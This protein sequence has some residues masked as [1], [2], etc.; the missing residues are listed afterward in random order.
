MGPDTG[1]GSVFVPAGHWIPAYAGMTRALNGA[2][3]AVGIKGGVNTFLSH[4]AYV[5]NANACCQTIPF[6]LE[7]RS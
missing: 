2:I 1:D 7:A 3:R 4:H 5:Q 6:R